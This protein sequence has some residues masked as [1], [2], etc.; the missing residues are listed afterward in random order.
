MIEPEVTIDDSDAKALFALLAGRFDSFEVP[1]RGRVNRA[2]RGMVRDQFSTQGGF[3]GGSWS[4][5]APSTLRAKAAKGTISKGILRDTDRLFNSIAQL[6]GQTADTIF[7]VDHFS[8]RYGTTV[9]YARFHQDGT[10]RM[11]Q[12]V[13]FP[14]PIPQAVTDEIDDSLCGWIMEGSGA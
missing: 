6:R 4:P 10:R 2:I 12:R 8:L 13:I 3:G 11:P 7:E 5:L 9:P 1:L 14:D